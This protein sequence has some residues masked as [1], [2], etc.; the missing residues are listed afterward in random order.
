M[1]PK[2]ATTPGLTCNPY[3]HTSVH[4]LVAH[5]FVGVIEISAYVC[6]EV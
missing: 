6:P 3:V 4:A 2:Y 5:V 1:R